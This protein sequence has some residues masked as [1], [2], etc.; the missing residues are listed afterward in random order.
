MMRVIVTGSRDWDDE[1]AIRLALALITQL[2]GSELTVVH[3]ACPTGADAIADRVAS[4]WGGGMTVERHPADWG[5]HGKAAGFIRNKGMVDLGADVVLAFQKN[6]SRG[7]Q[8][9]I[10]LARKAGIEVR[11]VTA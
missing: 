11:V 2:H 8:H 5:T 7:T 9:T 3:G 4:Q 10:D 6:K 1:Q